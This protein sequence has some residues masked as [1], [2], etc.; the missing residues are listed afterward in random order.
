MVVWWHELGEVENKC[1]L[2]DFSFFA[3]FL[4]KIIK[5]FMHAKFHNDSL[6]TI[7]D[8]FYWNFTKTVKAAILFFLLKI[9]KSLN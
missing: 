2:H 1:T 7:R 8:M 4:S 9:N 3:I 5:R 6:P